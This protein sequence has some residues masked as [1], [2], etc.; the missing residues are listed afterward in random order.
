V[1]LGPVR[2]TF[3][4]RGN[5]PAAHNELFIR[6]EQIGP[7][8]AFCSRR[9]SGQR[10]VGLRLQQRL[11]AVFVTGVTPDG[12]A[13]QNYSGRAH[14]WAQEQLFGER[15][16]PSGCWPMEIEPRAKRA[17]HG[18]RPP[19]GRPRPIIG[20]PLT[21]D[22]DTLAIGA[23]AYAPTA[24]ASSSFVTGARP[25]TRGGWTR[26]CVLQ[27]WPD[28]RRAVGPVN[29]NPPAAT[30]TAPIVPS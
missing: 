1:S 5:S 10:L 14:I 6:L 13:L 29:S 7:V 24:S 9:E 8:L 12:A 19:I 30:V 28:A 3:S 18:A 26:E 2:E 20:P 21:D 16:A 23:L 25:A 11:R 15:P 4:S 17:D 27:S 22:E